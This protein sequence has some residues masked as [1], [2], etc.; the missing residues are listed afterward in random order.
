MIECY[1]QKHQG[2]FEKYIAII[3]INI[4][5]LKENTKH[6]K[7]LENSRVFLSIYLI[8]IFFEVLSPRP[9]LF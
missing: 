8:A 4:L 2:Y 7:A 6:K 9:L 3:S 5:I 1:L